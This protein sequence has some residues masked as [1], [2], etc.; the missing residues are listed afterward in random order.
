LTPSAVE[1]APGGNRVPDRVEYVFKAPPI[2]FRE[3]PATPF[4]FAFIRARFL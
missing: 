3:Y 4:R 1:L 2:G